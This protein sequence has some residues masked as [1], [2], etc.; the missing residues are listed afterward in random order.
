MPE[1]VGYGP[2]NTLSVGKDIHVI[3]D[4]VYS[5]SGIETAANDP[6]TVYLAFITGNYYSIVNVQCYNVVD[7]STKI[8]WEFTLNGIKLFEYTQEGRAASIGIHMGQ[9][10][11][12]VIP[13]F[14]DVEVRGTTP[15]SVV[16]G[17]V[18]LT[19]KIY[20]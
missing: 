4:H 8:N 15:G 11:A 17:A 9:G 14:T 1:G 12:F 20:K 18:T 2:Q 10:N 7:D 19:G 5:F 3:G 16:A 6:G 13:P